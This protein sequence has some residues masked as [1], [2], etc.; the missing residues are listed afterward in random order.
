MVRVYPGKADRPER[1]L[2][3]PEVQNQVGLRKSS[4][5]EAIKNGSFPLPIKL[6][7]RSVCWPSSVIDAWIAER[8]SQTAKVGK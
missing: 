6:S 3:L 1:L 7:R 5:Y 4:I 8:I 2:R